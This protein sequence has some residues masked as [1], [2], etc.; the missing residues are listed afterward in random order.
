MALRSPSAARTLEL[1]RPTNAKGRTARVRRTTGS[2]IL[3]HS[4]ESNTSVAWLGFGGG[5]GAA[6]AAPWDVEEGRTGRAGEGAGRATAA[7]AEVDPTGGVFADATTVAEGT[8]DSG[9]TG[10]T[11]TAAA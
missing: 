6:R 8:S 9:G 7:S 1:Q 5:G 3:P 4:L 2:S 10:G 11:G